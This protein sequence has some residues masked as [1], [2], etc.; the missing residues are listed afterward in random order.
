MDDLF[1]CDSENILFYQAIETQTDPI[2][3]E[4]TL[5]YLNPLPV[6]AIVTDLGFSQIQWKM[7]G[8]LTDKAKEIIIDKKYEPLF[9]LAFKIKIGTEE[10]VGWK[11]NGQVQ[12][13]IEDD[14]LRAYVQLKQISD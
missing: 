6:P 5:T 2:Y 7:P 11:N 8:V 9:K 10:Y 12:Y 3:K 1:K 4:T 14:Y 13:R